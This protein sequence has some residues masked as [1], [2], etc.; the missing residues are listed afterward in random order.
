MN[1][2]NSEN[3][4]IP[5]YVF[6]VP[7]RNR[8]QHKQFFNVYMK[9]L[10][11][12]INPDN[13]KIVISHQC[14]K[15]HFNCGGVKN[16]GF[17]Y[18]KELYPNNYKDITFIFNDI[19]TLPFQKNLLNYSTIK[20][21]VKHF[22]GYKFALGGIISIKGEDFENINGYPNYWGY[23]YE[24]NVL[25]KRTK[26]NNL[27][28]NY[29]QFYPMG[30]KEILQFYDGIKKVMNKKNINRQLSKLRVETDGLNTLTDINYK[31]D[32]E[33]R[34]LNIYNF[35][36][37]YN[38]DEVDVHIHSLTNGTKVKHT[39]LKQMIFHRNN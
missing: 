6:I 24:D 22:Y 25:Y 19:D 38:H 21:E 8:E 29:K 23:G 20:G 35:N 39:P 37:L 4:I 11:E 32:E 33:T 16:I 15:R 1:Y 2:I 26:A 9:Y 36:G 10:L 12:D 14:D 3:S 28:M 31:Y 18:V 5:Q 17:L 34:M 13:Y 7:Y 27:N 30:S